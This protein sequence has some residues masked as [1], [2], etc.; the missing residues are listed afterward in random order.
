VVASEFTPADYLAFV[1][2]SPAA[3]AV[4]DKAAW[5]SLFA[6]CNIVED[7]VGSRPHLSGVYDRRDGHRGMGPLARFYETFIAPNDIRF[8]VERDVV[9]GMQ[10]VRDLS[11]EIAM[12]DSVIVRTPMHLLYQLVEQDGELKIFRLAAHW[13]LL[14]MLRQQMSAG[15]GSLWL[16]TQLGWRMLR[17]LGIGGTVGFM[18]ALSGIGRRG[19]ERVRAFQQSFNEGRDKDLRELFRD[20]DVAVEVSGTDGG[21]RALAVEQ[22]AAQ[23]GHLSFEKLIAAGNVVSASLCY[24][25]AGSE[26]HGVAFFEFDRRS[27]R[28]VALALHLQG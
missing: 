26:R 25:L 18:G 22:L 16:G 5:L 2:R 7:P 19:K 1:E 14:P 17:Q 27:R 11:I 6:R 10:V 4:H 20:D 12:S 23:G 13:E 28:I 3:V 9:T 8:L 21:F 15:R 24:R